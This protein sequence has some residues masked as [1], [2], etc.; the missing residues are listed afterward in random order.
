MRAP[1]VHRHARLVAFA[2][3]LGLLGLRAGT[4]D[5]RTEQLRWTHPDSATVDYFNVHYGPD[6]GNYTNVIPNL[7]PTPDAQG[8]YHYDLDVPDAD[9]V[10]AIVRAVSPEGRASIPSNESF[11]AGSG[12]PPPDPS[13]N[14]SIP[15]RMNG[16]GGDVVDVHGNTWVGDST[17]ALNGKV[18]SMTDTV[19]GT[20]LQVVYQTQRSGNFGVI[21]FEVP[22]DDG[23]YRLR[24]HFTENF[25]PAFVAGGRLF[26]IQVEGILLVD[27]LDIF[28]A[29]GGGLTA[30]VEEHVIDVDDGTLD[31]D[32]IQ[33]VGN[34]RLEGLEILRVGP[35]APQL[36]LP[37]PPPS[38]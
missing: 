3:L 30:H 4:A 17:Y 10:Y 24:L 37:G 33:Q 36:I 1:S 15:F 21:G 20:D 8:I 32:L 2:A 31:L 5:A 34:P 19:A 14:V 22:I 18:Y 35:I 25:A 9:H 26:D 12:D 6:S 11:R 7:T 16:G 27:D 29:A 13:G 23:T 28:T 38:S